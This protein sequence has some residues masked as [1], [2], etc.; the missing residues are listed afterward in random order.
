MVVRAPRAA[1]GWAVATWLVTHAAWYGIHD[2]RYD[3][4]VWRA[5]SGGRGWTPDKDTAHPGQVLAS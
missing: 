4:L 2:V 5:A 1:E 3:G